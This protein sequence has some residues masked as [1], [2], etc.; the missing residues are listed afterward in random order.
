MNADERR[1]V[2]LLV[3]LPDHMVSPYALCA[4]CPH[5]PRL[6][7]ARRGGRDEVKDHN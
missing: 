6:G 5:V 1:F 7:D 4:A 2:K 3:G